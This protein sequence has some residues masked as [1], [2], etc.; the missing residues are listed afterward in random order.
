MAVPQHATEAQKKIIDAAVLF[1][2]NQTSDSPIIQF[3]LIEGSAGSGKTATV[4]FIVKAIQS[5]LRGTKFDIFI[6]GFSLD[7][8]AKLAATLDQ[9]PDKTYDIYSCTLHAFVGIAIQADADSLFSKR[10]NYQPFPYNYPSVAVTPFGKNGEK[11]TIYIIDE[12]YLCDPLC[13]EL[14]INRIISFSNPNAKILVIFMGDPRQIMRP[15]DEGYPPPLAVG[16]IEDA[17][18]PITDQHNIEYYPID[19]L[20]ASLDSIQDT[21]D[22]ERPFSRL[23]R[24]TLSENIRQQSDPQY[25]KFLENIVSEN[26]MNFRLLQNLLQEHQANQIV[27]VSQFI[28]RLQTSEF[29]LVGTSRDDIN[30]KAS[31]Y[32]QAQFEGG[33]E[34]T[35]IQV[36]TGNEVFYLSLTERY[37]ASSQLIGYV[38][39]FCPKEFHEDPCAKPLSQTN[40]VTVKIR[41]GTRLNIVNSFFPS[42]DAIRKK[43]PK[44]R[45]YVEV[46]ITDLHLLPDPT[47]SRVFIPLKIGDPPP[48]RHTSFCTPESLQ[49]VTISRQIRLVLDLSQTKYLPGGTLY[50]L[51]S[52]A[53]SFDCMYFSKR[54][55]DTLYEA[56]GN[57]HRLTPQCIFDRYLKK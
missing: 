53:P 15:L 24:F 13:I 26:T 46:E 42:D 16:E 35:I 38:S 19:A 2:T 30:L 20:S 12:I 34:Q 51:L 4:Q 28:V 29:I 55:I 43:S 54:C 8:A 27:D 14:A 10:L 47:H 5:I 6:P 18:D 32:F 25:L 17:S 1:V 23:S 49:G 40:V 37:A 7:I 22:G 21:T 52:R 3:I 48:F 56:A 9:N 33:D 45:Y 31:K 41:G 39:E 11:L 57:S 36:P 44:L 50:M